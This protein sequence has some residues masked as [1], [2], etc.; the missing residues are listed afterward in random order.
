MSQ[1]IQIRLEYVNNIFTIIFLCEMV[2]KIIG[3]GYKTYFSDNFDKFD[4]IIVMIST[5]DLFI[6]LLI[7]TTGD[8]FAGSLSVFR[9]LKLLRMF[10][11]MRIFR[12]VNKVAALKILTATLGAAVADVSYLCIIPFLLVFMFATL[13]VSLFAKDYANIDETKLSAR[14][15][16]KNIGLSMITVFQVVTGDNWTGI[17]YSNAEIT[18]KSWSFFFFLAIVIF[19]DFILMNLFVAVLLTKIGE[20]SLHDAD[21]WLIDS[22]TKE[23]R[24]LYDSDLKYQQ[25]ILKLCNISQHL[26]FEKQLK[27]LETLWLPHYKKQIFIKKWAL[28]GKSL[29]IF[30]TKSYIRCRIYSIV[31]TQ[32]FEWFIAILIVIN[33]IMLAFENPSMIETQPNIIKIFNLIDIIFVCI[34]SFEMIFK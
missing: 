8:K 4:F 15:S 19:G 24:K 23:A 32:W 29:G 7:G 14:H 16:F 31:H 1:E 28:I 5:I 34:Y 33:C 17:M 2:I 30:T 27:N 10:R 26:R 3:L 9:S 21:Q 13:G 6:S 25:K 20:A 18:G 22:L 12:V 11:I